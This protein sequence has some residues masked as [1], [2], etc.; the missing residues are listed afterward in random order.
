MTVADGAKQLEGSRR[1]A[2]GKVIFPR[3]PTTSPAAGLFEP[4]SLSDVAELYSY[5]V[6]HSSR[7]EQPTILIYADFPEGARVLGR[8]VTSEGS[9]PRIGMRVKPVIQ[10]DR[11]SDIQLYHFEPATEHDG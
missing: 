3:V 5:T 7:G 6:I 1:K 11:E 10:S 2:S 8:L 4:V 9:K